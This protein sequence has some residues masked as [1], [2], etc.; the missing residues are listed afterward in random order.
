MGARV[1]AGW[2]YHVHLLLQFALKKG[3]LYIQLVEVYR[4]HLCHGG[5]GLFAID[6]MC[7]CVSFRYESRFVAVDRTFGIVLYLVYPSTSDHLF[8]W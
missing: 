4:R 7:L 8:V 1:E 6:A 3:V 5:K 2:L